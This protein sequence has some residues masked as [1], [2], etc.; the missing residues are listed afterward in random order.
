MEE[1]GFPPALEIAAVDPVAVDTHKPDDQTLSDGV[2]LYVLPL[3]RV[4]VGTVGSSSPFDD[5]IE[6]AEAALAAKGERV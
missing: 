3:N 6:P 2:T 5:T 1:H 4:T